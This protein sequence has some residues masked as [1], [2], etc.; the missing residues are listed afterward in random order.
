M[1]DF[2]HPMAA[3][4]ECEVETE[5]LIAGGGPCG[6]TL[7]NEL[8]RRGIR[9]LL[10]DPKP[11]TAFNPHLNL[12]IKH[13]AEPPAL[14]EPEPALA[15]RPQITATTMPGLPSPASRDLTPQAGS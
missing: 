7:A 1:T 10:V 4:R 13:L 3:A 5:I 2:N 14:P 11:G 6:L 9:C 8:G 15:T 12:R